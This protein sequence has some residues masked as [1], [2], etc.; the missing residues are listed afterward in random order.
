MQA[1]GGPTRNEFLMQFT[2]DITQLAW[3]VSSVPESSALGA[4]MA[5]LLGLGKFSTLY[6]L[7]GL[8]RERRAI[9]S[10]DVTSKGRRASLRMA[11]GCPPGAVDLVL[12]TS[13]SGAT[14]YCVRSRP[15][16]SPD[17]AE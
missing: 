1:D 14:L 10:P 16:Q 4:A 7:A 17:S 2:A 11:D 8:P 15:S 6:D 12:P 3:N 5:G 13:C 9:C